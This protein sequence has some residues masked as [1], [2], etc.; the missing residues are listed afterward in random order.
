MTILT[1][2]FYKIYFNIDHYI[3]DYSNVFE[4]Y[5]ILNLTSRA[6]KSNEKDMTENKETETNIFNFLV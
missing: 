3:F 2:F 4:F 6:S 1:T 5:F